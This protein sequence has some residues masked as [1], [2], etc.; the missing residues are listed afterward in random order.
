MKVLI[1]G[2]SRG[3]GLQLTKIALQKFDS[4]WAVT[5]NPKSLENL[6]REFPQK[7]HVIEAEIGT[8]K[9]IQ[10][11]A[12]T[13]EAQGELDILINNAG[14]LVKE[15]DEK[16]LQESFQINTIAPFLLTKRLI[17]SLEKSKNPRVIQI[18]TMMA[19]I[20]DNGSGGYY[21]YRGSKAALNMMTKSLSLDHRNITFSLLHPGWVKTEMGGPQA[22]V[23]PEDSAQRLWAIIESLKPSSELKYQ[24]F[25]GKELPW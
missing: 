12:Q 22:L 4:V 25:R 2:C 17:P 10:K 8:E 21:A 20:A 24:D 14:I 16:S 13:I 1:T 3:I 7:L 9:G 11:V 15:H 5:R 18:S 19:S 6:K 23:E